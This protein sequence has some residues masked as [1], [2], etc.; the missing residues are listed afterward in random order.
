MKDITTCIGDIF[1]QAVNETQLFD[2]IRSF[3]VILR[4]SKIKAV[5]VVTHFFH[6]AFKFISQVI[7]KNKKDYFQINLKQS[8]E[9]NILNLKVVMKLVESSSS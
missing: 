2:R 9:W 1:I 3:H 8:N 4:K 5:L 6:A 7:T